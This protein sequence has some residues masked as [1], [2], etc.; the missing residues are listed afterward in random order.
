MS[1]KPEEFWVDTEFTS[2]ADDQGHISWSGE[3][4][5]PLVGKSELTGLALETE[6]GCSQR[7]HTLEVEISGAKILEKIFTDCEEFS[8]DLY[9]YLEPGAKFIVTLLAANFGASE[10][11]KGKISVRIRWSLGATEQLVNFRGIVSANGL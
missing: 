10:S 7:Q 9:F 4:E 6:S 1:N 8:S 2:D 11:V 5:T 3:I